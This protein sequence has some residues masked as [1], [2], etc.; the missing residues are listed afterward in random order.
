[1]GNNITPQFGALL[2]AER[3][4]IKFTQRDMES[5]LRI[6]NYAKF[7]SGVR[8]PSE[9]KTWFKLSHCFGW[10]QKKQAEMQDKLMKE[11][12]SK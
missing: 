12:G 8:Y 1:M 9:F 4:R 3:E 2:K 11:L 6:T 10:S 7:E 5:T